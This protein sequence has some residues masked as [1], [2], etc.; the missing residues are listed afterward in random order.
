MVYM[1]LDLIAWY[2]RAVMKG[3]G[4]VG[5]MKY[6]IL[7]WKCG[8]WHNMFIW[9]Y[10]KGWFQLGIKC[11]SRSAKIVCNIANHYNFEE[12]S[13]VRNLRLFFLSYFEGGDTGETRKT[14]KRDGS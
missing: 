9:A 11:A 10:R 3:D 14:T 2:I 6:K 1:E 7:M 12:R 5:Y 13:W 8:F 4:V